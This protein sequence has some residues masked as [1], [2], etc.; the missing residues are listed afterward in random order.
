MQFSFFLKKKK[1][2]KYDR[3]SSAC[4]KPS[5]SILAGVITKSPKKLFMHDNN[6]IK[7]QQTTKL[8]Q[9]ARQQNTENQKAMTTTMQKDSNNIHRPIRGY[10]GGKHYRAVVP[11][12]GGT[13][14]SLSLN[15]SLATPITATPFPFF[16]T[17]P[18][19]NSNTLLFTGLSSKSRPSSSHCSCG[20]T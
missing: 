9:L 13:I 18:V 7:A 10:R 20:I 5:C 3:I 11:A 12:A 6:S 8:R 17:P 16:D 1:K 2:I 14:F 15:T 19:P 4:Q